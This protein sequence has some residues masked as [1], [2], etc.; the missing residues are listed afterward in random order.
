[1]WVS[2]GL[3]LCAG[4]LQSV[5]AGGSYCAKTARARAAALGLDYPGVHGAPEL[6]GPPRHT[7]PHRNHYQN[8]PES[9]NM[10]Y[11]PVQYRDALRQ[12]PDYLAQ[13]F[14]GTS[15][16]NMF[17]LNPHSPVHTDYTSKKLPSR[18]KGQSVSNRES[19]FEQVKH[20]GPPT[21]TRAPGRA[22][23]VNW[24][25]QGRSEPRSF[26]YNEHNLAVDGSVPNR[27]GMFLSRLS[28]PRSGGHGVYHRGSGLDELGRGREIP[29]LGSFPFYNNKGL[30]SDMTSRGRLNTGDFPGPRMW[31]QHRNHGGQYVHGNRLIKPNARLS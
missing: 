6:L 18:A 3:F 12:T 1:M 21:L 23:L 8:T 13:A 22:D 31:A 4:V 20:V 5:S 28:L 16:P 19:N 27:H 15:E 25:S 14:P 24:A 11:N 7:R 2:L 29:V 17:L 9:A 26:V 30:V 10:D